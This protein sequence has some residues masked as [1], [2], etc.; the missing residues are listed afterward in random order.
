MMGC[1]GRL[2]FIDAICCIDPVFIFGLD[3][4]LFIYARNT[5]FSRMREVAALLIEQDMCRSRTKFG[6]GVA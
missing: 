1:F 5:H 6:E 4:G 2:T 3:A